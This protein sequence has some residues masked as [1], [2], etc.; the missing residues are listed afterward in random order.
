MDNINLEQGDT[1]FRN[2]LA[3]QPGGSSG[4]SNKPNRRTEQRPNGG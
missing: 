2:E 3:K 4:R 1:N